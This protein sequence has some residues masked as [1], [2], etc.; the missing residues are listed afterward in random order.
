MK[1]F[2]PLSLFLFS[3]FF[4]LGQVSIPDAN[5]ETELIAQ[6]ID[7]DGIVNGEISSA[8][9]LA[10]TGTLNL[11]NKGISDL[12]GIESFTNLAQLRFDDNSVSSV[13]VSTLINLTQLR[14]ANNN[15]SVINISNNLNLRRL[16]INGNTGIT[17]LNIDNN[18]ALT[19]LFAFEN[20][21]SSINIDNNVALTTVHLYGNSISTINLDNNTVLSTLLIQNNNISTISVTLNTA[22]TNFRIQ[23][24]LLTILDVSTNTLLEDLRCS[25]NN[26][27]VL[28]IS[29]NTSLTQLRCQNNNL[30]RLYAQNGNN[31]SMT[32]FRAQNNVPLTCIDVDDVAYADANFTKDS[33][34]VFSTDCDAVLN[35]EN[36]FD[37]SNVFIY[38]NPIRNRLNIQ[39]NNL[40][41]TSIEIFDIKG[42]KIIEKE[43]PSENINLSSLNNGLYFIKF[44]TD[45]NILIRKFIKE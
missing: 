42:Q 4:I 10:K 43:S 15:L 38:P 29:S 7:T 30:T 44:Y 23:D 13:N 18:V 17:T 25:D 27:E 32:I 6:G 36:V 21:L 31:T 5:F 37:N 34:A 9:A 22:L 20:G 24:N 39:T 26:L 16:Y 14:C 3:S 40:D 2:I 1:K 33:G 28:D 11:N 45:T 41:V 35:T 12:T 19:H 8:D